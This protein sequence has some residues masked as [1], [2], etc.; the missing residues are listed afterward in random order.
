M[1]SIFHMFKLEQLGFYAV[2]D[3]KC[4][5]RQENECQLEADMER[6]DI[7]SLVCLV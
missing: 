4:I 5:V 6:E 7:K 3:W 2:Q 1:L